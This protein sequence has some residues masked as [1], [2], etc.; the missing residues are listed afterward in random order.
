MIGQTF[1]ASA[2]V[3]YRNAGVHHIRR[4]ITTV[5][6]FYIETLRLT[7]RPITMGCQMRPFSASEWMMIN[8]NALLLVLIFALASCAGEPEE[9]QATAG[10]WP[11][12]SRDIALV[13]A[14]Q[15]DAPPSD[16]ARLDALARDA[17]TQALTR[18]GY[19]VVSSAPDQIELGISA[20]PAS[21][22]IE[23]KDGQPMAPALRRHFP[24]SCR[25]TSYRLTLAYFRGGSIVAAGHA[26]ADD[27]HCHG[28]WATEMPVLA[29]AVVSQITRATS[30][31]G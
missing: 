4:K 14:P 18:H 21:L 25:H 31:A 16:A 19:D 30:P 23:T 1:S 9:R 2:S 20:R 22:G 10:N 5:T 15:P 8:R 13:A 6:R 17:V 28:S 27:S 7:A 12:P 3:K 26:A 11:P 29:E 24:Q